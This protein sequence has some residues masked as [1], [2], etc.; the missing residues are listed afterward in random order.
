[1]KEIIL[2][3]G[4][5]HAKAVID[6]IEQTDMYIIA[7]IVDK[8]ELVG[9]E[10]LGYKVVGC[11][12]DLAELRKKIPNAIV[13]V[14]HIRSN[15][16]RIKLYDKLK[17]LDFA[18]PS[19][20]SP[21]AYIAKGAFVDEGSVVMHHAIVNSGASIGKNSIINTKALIEHDCVVQDH[22]HIST[23]AILNGDVTVKESSFVGSGAV[24][25]EGSVV[26]GF[27]KAGSVYK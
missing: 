7:G 10:V 14:G 6:V 5:G 20:I 3:G 19:I 12:D 24:V 15:T 16:T 9:S 23:G 18:L 11:D 2:I 13:S 4:G 22:T 25:I 21:L 8:K 17:E 1:M 27:V 26:D